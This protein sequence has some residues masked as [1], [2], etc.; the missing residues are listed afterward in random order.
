MLSGYT[1]DLR[2]ALNDGNAYRKRIDIHRRTKHYEG[3]IRDTVINIVTPAFILHD[4]QGKKN[5]YRISE[6]GTERT[7]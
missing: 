1:F 6:A 3:I 7:C 5:G 4:M 2:V